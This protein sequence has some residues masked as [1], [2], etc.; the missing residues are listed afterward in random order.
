M[1][2][3]VG[4]IIAALA[5][6]AAA[7]VPSTYFSRS[8]VDLDDDS[9]SAVTKDPAALTYVA[10]F[11]RTKCPKCRTFRDVY[12]RAAKDLHGLASF[13][14]VDVTDP[15]AAATVAAANL[16][17]APLPQL[18]AYSRTQSGALVPAA[19][20]LTAK[21]LRERVEADVQALSGV[22]KVTSANFKDVVKKAPAHLG[23]ALL[24]TTK[25][26][27]TPTWAAISLAFK[28]RLVVGE[29]HKSDKKLVKKY[30]ITEFPSV[31]VI[32]PTPKGTKFDSIE[33]RV[34]SGLLKAQPLKA[35]L[36]LHAADPPAGSPSDALSLPELSDPSCFAAHCADLGGLCAIYVAPAHQPR[37]Q[38]AYDLDILAAVADLRP[39][40]AVHYAWVDGARHGAWAKEALGIEPQEYAQL[41]ALQ[42]R[43][44]LVAPFVGSFRLEDINRW[45]L[46]LQAGRADTVSVPAGELPP[47]PT[48]ASAPADGH[49]GSLLAKRAR[50]AARAPAP[51]SATESSSA[52]NA[53]AAAMGGNSAG[54]Q[55]ASKAM[56]WRKP[57]RPLGKRG[58]VVAVTD[59][60]A[61][62]V[63]SERSR[64]FVARFVPAAG[65]V[66]D[67]DAEAAAAKAFEDA[68]RSVNGMV[69]FVTVQCGSDATTSLQE[70]WL[71]KGEQ[72]KCGGQVLRFAAAPSLKL[73][74]AMLDPAV[75]SMSAEDAAESAAETL[76]AHGAA[77]ARARAA[78]AEP[79]TGAAEL[80]PLAAW[81]LAS[82]DSVAVETL[83]G[84]AEAFQRW[85]LQ[86]ALI[87]RVLIA[88]DKQDPPALARALAAEFADYAEVGIVPASNTALMQQFQ[89]QSTPAVRL[90]RPTVKP[91]A[92]GSAALQFDLVP[93]ADQALFFN[94]VARALDAVVGPYHPRAA[95]PKVQVSHESGAN[96]DEL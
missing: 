53:A 31:I 49:C 76:A 96:K 16:G 4:L 78:A 70:Q 9:F 90:V 85:L 67:A 2:R 40:A 63:V 79:Y 83:S 80:K 58:E 65:S 33:P 6:L 43:K 32:P 8:I 48:D 36:R 22:V 86:N 45:A 69:A 1:S 57:S 51:A 30:E 5:A 39:A 23:K 46:D 26:E 28:D 27:T 50:R 91:S 93:V 35:F 10:F 75:A 44:L 34:Y 15:E 21:T 55:A 77:L 84:N 13:A 74:A 14:A 20:E 3:L 60:T 54:A 66:A 11:S 37:R 94:A 25:R 7:Q 88:T 72:G 92:D 89:I 17:D 42:P 52:D 68:G 73:P 24:F 19:A 95:A 61:A 82:L 64:P 81:A 62:A 41:A 71:P 29:V 38:T 87:P 12:D 59:E 47:L 56:Y 18:R